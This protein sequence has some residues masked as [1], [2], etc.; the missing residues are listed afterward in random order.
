[1]FKDINVKKTNMKHSKYCGLF[2]LFKALSRSTS[3]KDALAHL[4]RQAVFAVLLL[5]AFRNNITINGIPYTPYLLLGL[6]PWFYLEQIIMGAAKS[7]HD[8]SPLL[9]AHGKSVSWLSL[10]RAFTALPILLLFLSAAIAYILITKGNI[11]TL[12]AIPY[13]IFCNIINAVAQGQMAIA[14]LPIIGDIAGEGFSML[15]AILF[16]STPIA[17][18]IGKIDGIM[19]FALRSNPLYYISESGRSIFYNGYDNGAASTVLFL[20]SVLVVF[21]AGTIL[22]HA[23]NRVARGGKIFLRRVDIG[24]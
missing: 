16:W 23:L 17:W 5:L 4:L 11:I 13:Y 19:L 15:T 6:A 22:Y 7:Y 20:L 12:K 9:S 21:T 14:L 1:M 8:F 10:C 18:P 24:L 3:I 2:A